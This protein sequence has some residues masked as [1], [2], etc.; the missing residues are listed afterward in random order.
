MNATGY[1]VLGYTVWHGG[2]W[3]LRRNY[4]RKL[5]VARR[6]AARGGLLVL[7]GGVVVVISRRG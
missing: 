7:L 1:K 4:S 2:K 5:S 3:Y 6:Y